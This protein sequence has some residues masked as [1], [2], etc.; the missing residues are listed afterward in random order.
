MTSAHEKPT[1]ASGA[2]EPK[3]DWSD[4]PYSA[5]DPHLFTKKNEQDYEIQNAHGGE[6]QVVDRFVNGSL[7]VGLRIAKQ[8]KL[9]DEQVRRMAKR[10]INKVLSSGSNA[11]KLLEHF[12]LP[13]KDFLVAAKVGVLSLLR[14]GFPDQAVKMAEGFEL[15]GF[16]TLPIVRGAAEKGFENLR[17]R[18]ESTLDGML[19]IFEF[20]KKND[21]E[22]AVV[23]P[24]ETQKLAAAYIIQEFKTTHTEKA[25]WIAEHLGIP[26]EVLRGAAKNAMVFSYEYAQPFVSHD[27]EER[28]GI[29]DADKALLAKEAVFKAFVDQPA[30]DAMG[31][32][33][34]LK[35]K[36][37]EITELAKRG[38]S[39]LVI[40]GKIGQAEE[41]AKTANLGKDAMRDA[42]L[43]RVAVLFKQD[44]LD[45]VEI[46]AAQFELPA[47]EVKALVKAEIMRRFEKGE[48]ESAV[49]FA[50]K[51]KIGQDILKSPEVQAAISR[52]V[53]RRL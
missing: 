51:A 41:L 36:K 30:K 7:E 1:D 29:T 21:P 43:E 8:N 19:A 4:L 13:K 32:A 49:R 9:S 37:E 42:K 48:T 22:A 46:E 35:L 28:F 53:M 38:L 31:R 2:E 44:R 47:K 15:K 16:E 20:L 26:E 18:K 25:D 27:L 10:A 33:K 23:I 40:G 6:H 5:D 50:E 17:G 3:S 11:D 14:M 34:D 52:G 45:E 12:H 39:E 24:P